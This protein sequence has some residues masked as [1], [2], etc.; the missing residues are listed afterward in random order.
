M[1]TDKEKIAAEIERRKTKAIVQKR[2][3]LATEYEDIASFIY[4]LPKEPNPE[5]IIAQERQLRSDIYAQLVVHY[6]PK[7]D[8]GC[9]H[10]YT[11]LYNE[12]KEAAGEFMS[13]EYGKIYID[14]KEWQQK[15]K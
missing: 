8:L 9:D 13:H 3:F 1:A 6:A 7:H 10:T 12:A 14:A 4:N 2:L 5:E 15:A 11:N